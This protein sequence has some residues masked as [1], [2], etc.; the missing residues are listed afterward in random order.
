M[1]LPFDNDNVHDRTI[2]SLKS[3]PEG[4]LGG[5]IYIFLHPHL[6]DPVHDHQQV[7]LNDALQQFSSSLLHLH[8]VLPGKFIISL[9][10]LI[11]S[12]CNKFSTAF[13]SNAAPA[14]SKTVAGTQLGAPKLNLKGTVFPFSII[15]STPSIP[16]TLAISCGSLTVPM[17]P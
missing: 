11:S 13:E 7:F 17:V 14:V 2:R 4:D 16:H 10:Y 1:V 5:R 12:R 3:P 8:S 15:N 9:R 6:S